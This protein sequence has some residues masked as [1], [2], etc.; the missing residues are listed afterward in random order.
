MKF[1]RGLS[2]KVII[3]CVVVSLLAMSVENAWGQNQTETLSPVLTD[4][5]LPFSLEINEANFSLQAGIHSYVSAIHKG[6]WILLG[7]RTDGFHGFDC[8][9]SNFSPAFQNRQ[10]H[11]VDPATGIAL[12]KSLEDSDLNPLQMDAL[13]AAK[14]QFFQ[15]GNKLYIAG[16]YGIDSATG[17]IGTKDTLT[18]V[19]LDKVMDWAAG[20]TL[21]LSRALRQITHPLLQV[22]SG[23]LFQANNHEPFLLMLGQKAPGLC[24]SD[25]NGHCTM[26]IRPFWLNDSGGN[27]SIIP[28]VSP[29]TYPDYRRQ[30]PNIAPILHNNQFAYIA[31][32][33]IFTLE[34][35]VW[36]VPIKI[37]PNGKSYEPDPHEAASFKQAMNHYHCPSFGLYSSSR[38]EMFVVF[39]GGI[40]YGFFSNGTF[41]TDS[42][43]PFINQVTTI[44]IDKNN[45]YTQHL[46]DGE[47]PYIASTGS[48]PPNQLLFGAEASFFPKDDI[49]LYSNGVI[50]YDALSK[51]R[52]V[53]GY[54]V[55][56][57][58]SS[59]PNTNT[60]TDSTSSP[61][62]FTVTL[63]PRSLSDKL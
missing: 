20:D 17:E 61:Y 44:K 49:S 25:P 35:G 9:V 10:V 59:Q 29:V 38:N 33:G 3:V 7:G 28:H 5:S 1:E 11:V 30:D 37:L 26:Q 6:K 55:G 2:I 50:Q 47:F 24:H 16:G 14:A 53:I 27:L 60:N 4:A 54:I 40:S 56:G 36:T 22:T 13:S 12:H 34:A 45:I 46:M 63:V 42:G 62:V 57:I 15:K 18:E 52:T 58:M 21:Q 23:F 39:P 31:F 43:I 51:D 8:A 41:S 48:S 19:N 32:A